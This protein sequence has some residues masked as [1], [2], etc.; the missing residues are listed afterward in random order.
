MMKVEYEKLIEIVQNKKKRKNHT[1]LY[2]DCIYQN[3][4]PYRNM[5]DAVLSPLMGTSLMG[6]FR[7]IGSYKNQFN[8]HYV[9]LYSNKEEIYWQDELDE[10]QGLYIYYGDNQQAGRDLHDTKLGGNRILREVFT[11]AQSKN[12]EDRKK[13]PPFF[14][15]EKN[16][17]GGVKFSGL[18]VPGYGTLNEKEWLTSLWAKREE[19]GRFQ[20]Y[21][22]IFT[23]LNT[24]EGSLASKDDASIDLNWLE[25]LKNGK[26]YES[27]YAPITWKKWIQT[28][29]YNPLIVHATPRIRSKE[30]QLPVDKEKKEMLQYIYH[31]FQINPYLFEQFAIHIVKLADTHILSCENTRPTKD[32]GRDGIGEY[33]I[34][35]AFSHRLKVTFA[36]EA[37]CYHPDYGAGVKDTSRLISRIKNRQFGIFVTTSYVSKQAYSEIIE[38]AHPIA[39]LAGADII[40]ILYKNAITNISLLKSFLRNNFPIDI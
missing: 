16:Q 14:L 23:V 9:V 17:E 8:V 5:S 11:L 4:Q 3:R 10:E 36:L 2:I 29:A 40:M 37:K 24:E 1:K 19:G 31:Y 25:D 6:G 13:I 21:K 34:L 20:N 15:F 7:P 28:G 27:I 33:T 32:G 18:L 35:N 30:E 22:A 12:I 39:I 38:D 26:G